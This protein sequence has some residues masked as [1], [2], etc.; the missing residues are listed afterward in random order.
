MYPQTPLP[1][2]PTYTNLTPLHSESVPS[3]VFTG[4]PVNSL[5]PMS[6]F[7]ASSDVTQLWNHFLQDNIKGRNNNFHIANYH[8]VH[9]VSPYFMLHPTKPSAWFI[10]W[11]G[12]T[13]NDN[14][15]SMSRLITGTLL[16]LKDLSVCTHTHALEFHIYHCVLGLPFLHQGGYTFYYTNSHIFTHE[17]I[18][19]VDCHSRLSY[20]RSGSVSLYSGQYIQVMVP[21]YPNLAK[22]PHR[23]WEYRGEQQQ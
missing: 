11:P 21:G 20:H 12:T 7:C 1:T 15:L 4:T 5:N 9:A 8:V 16:C 18:S 3:T 19:C 10:T 22:P 6:M 13:E 23:I 2:E 17:T 14:L